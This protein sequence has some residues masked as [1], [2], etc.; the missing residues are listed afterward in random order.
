[1]VDA[2]ACGAWALGRG[3]A[4][5]RRFTATTKTA[6]LGGAARIQ[7]DRS[8]A[9]VAE[10]EPIAAAAG[11]NGGSSKWRD[12]NETNRGCRCIAARSDGR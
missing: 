4:E 5:R 1:M 3:G 12:G 2:F 9:N 8:V 11:K 7:R 6:Q 10:R